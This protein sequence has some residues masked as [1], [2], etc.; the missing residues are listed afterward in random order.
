MKL[1][2]MQGAF[3]AALLDEEAPPPA[4][5][6]DREQA[7]LAIYRNN[8]RSS[9]LDALTETYPRT[10]RW[11]GQEPFHAAGAHHLISCPPNG[12]SLDDAGRGFAETLTGLFPGDP[13]VAELAWIE[14]AMACAFTA[15]DCA[16]FTAQDFAAATTGFNDGQWNDLRLR[17]APGLALREVAHDLPPLWNALAADEPSLAQAVLRPLPAPHYC[18]VW[19]EGWRSTFILVDEDEGLALHHLATGGSYGEACALL[20]ERMDETAALAKAGTMLGNWLALGLITGIAT[21]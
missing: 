5:W 1:A 19:R 3:M 9:L 13:E 11:V 16:P 14:W 7:G 20:L 21:I 18:T 2:D 8:Y 15:A 10:L 17:M 12:W 6:N 4:Q